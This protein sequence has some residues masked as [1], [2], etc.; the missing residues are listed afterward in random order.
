MCISVVSSCCNSDDD[1]AP[2][3]QVTDNTPAQNQLL[4][5]VNGL[6]PISTGIGGMDAAYISPKGYFGY[7]QDISA[8]SSSA[9]AN[10]KYSSVTYMT[11]DGS[12]IIS[13]ITT[14]DD[15]I[16]SQM[17][18]KNG[19]VYFSFPND[20]ILELVYDDG[21][22]VT[23]L[24]SI[25]YTKEELPGFKFASGLDSFRAILANTA[26]LLKNGST[27][28][29]QGTISSSSLFNTYGTIFEETSSL[30]YTTDDGIVA[31]L[32]TDGSTNYTFAVTINNWYNGEIESNVSNTISLWT[33]KATYKV[34]GSSCTLSGTI[35]C[36]SDIFNEYGTYGIVCDEDATKLLVNTAEYEGTG[37]QAEDA[38][39]YSVDF[40]GFKPNT[41]YYYRAYYKFNSGQHGG[42]L[43]KHGNASD[44]VIYDTTIKSFRTGENILSVDVLMCIDVTGSMSGIINT[45]KSNAI[46]FYDLFKQS[47]EEEGIT[48]TSLN[49]QVIA[50]RDKN[51]DTDWL[52]TSTTYSLPAQQSEYNSF[53]NSL[54]A[55]G[56]GDIAESGL[57]ALKQAFAKSDWGADDGYHRQVVILWTDA[58]YLTDSYSDVSLASLKTQW[59]NM[60]SGRRMVL[61]APYGTA[62]SYSGDWGALDDWT[63]LIHETDLANGF[64]NFEYILKSIISELTSKAKARDL[65]TRTAVPYFQPNN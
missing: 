29:I 51:E 28:A 38:L 65:K 62:E 8:T 61:F 54:Y 25:A 30:H 22:T 1:A 58:P 23:M 27:T 59:D 53:V 10:G 13:I 5:G 2:P 16:P 20:S 32:P 3:V 26:A 56:G 39:S 43:P 46:G 4:Q 47:C 45:V 19:I 17:L 36:A 33:G 21:N 57:E 37:H 52:Q 64:N 40:R 11:A 31:Q 44:D 15:A 14:K 18:T 6:I 42:L 9:S 34:G 50:F 7:K 12:D 63:N 48:L 60:P 41:T 55:N 24:D 49:A 35:W